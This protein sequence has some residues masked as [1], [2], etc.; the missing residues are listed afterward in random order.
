M[1]LGFIGA[2]NV[3]EALGNRWAALGHTIRFGVRNPA[4][5]KYQKLISGN[6]R[7][8]SIPEAVKSADV[9]VLATPWQATR[10]A[11]A[12]AGDLSGK[13]ILDATNPWVYP[14]GLMLGFNTSGGEE[15]AKWAKGAKVVKAMNQVGSAV[16]VDTSYAGSVKPSM[17]V[18]GDDL[19]AKATVMNLVSDL[20]FE[21]IDFGPLSGARLLE[22]FAAV[23]IDLALKH[24][25]GSD[26]AFGILRK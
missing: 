2:G 14:Q 5:A 19:M 25:Q 3:G 18:A 26:F 12:S 21:T 7:V 6:V 15:V 20:G 9:V 13:I 16:M 17:F 8:T 10:E 22:P 23:W 24:K 4:D 11:I 1:N